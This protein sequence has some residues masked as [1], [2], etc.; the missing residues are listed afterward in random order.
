MWTPTELQ[1][2]ASST[3]IANG[4]NVKH[5]VLTFQKESGGF[6]DPTIQSQYPNPNGPNEK[7][8]SWG[9]CQIDLDYH[10]DISREQATDPVW[11]L[12]WAAQQWANGHASLWSA[13][14]QFSAHG[15]PRIE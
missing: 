14:K 5:F 11:C 8:N 2:L 1:A 15:W 6:L 4:L 10:P 13:W 3:A 7:E 9:I 12:T